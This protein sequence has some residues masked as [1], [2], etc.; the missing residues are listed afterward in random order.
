[1]PKNASKDIVNLLATAPLHQS[2]RKRIAWMII[3]CPLRISTVQEKWHQFADRL[4]FEMA[5][6]GQN[7]KTR[8]PMDAQNGGT[9]SHTVEHSLYQKI[10]MVGTLYEPNRT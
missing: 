6:L 8:F 1:M 5:V 3:N 4:H 10:G 9:F 2:W 7:W